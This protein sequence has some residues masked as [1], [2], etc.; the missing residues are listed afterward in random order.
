MR[1]EASVVEVATTEYEN[2]PLLGNGKESARQ[3]SMLV[4]G[5]LP[6]VPSE[7]NDNVSSTIQMCVMPNPL[8]TSPSLT[9]LKM[10]QQNKHNDR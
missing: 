7:E 5:S 8:R 4:D 6:D 2:S 9:K 1:G 10:V 3:S